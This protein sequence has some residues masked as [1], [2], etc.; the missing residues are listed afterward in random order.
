MSDTIAPYAPNTLRG[1]WPMLNG[2]VKAPELTYYHKQSGKKGKAAQ[3]SLTHFRYQ[4]IPSHW[5]EMS[6]S[7]WENLQKTKPK[8]TE[9]FQLPV[10]ISPLRGNTQKRKSP[11]ERVDPGKAPLSFSSKLDRKRSGKTT[12]IVTSAEAAAK[13]PRSESPDLSKDPVDILDTGL[14]M[15]FQPLKLNPDWVGVTF[16]PPTKI[17]PSLNLSDTSKAL[18][19]MILRRY[20]IHPSRLTSLTIWL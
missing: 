16:D 9:E 1:G 11:L 4:K 5:E 13:K 15:E 19:M 7:A 10:S 6:K 18:M 8:P 14:P 12:A 2:H 20:V 3:Y 17:Y